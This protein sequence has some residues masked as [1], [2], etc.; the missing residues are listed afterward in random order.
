M[1][2]YSAIVLWGLILWKLIKNLLLNFHKILV[3]VYSEIETM[4]NYVAL[5]TKI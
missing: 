1:N 3:D 5:I 4:L 2:C